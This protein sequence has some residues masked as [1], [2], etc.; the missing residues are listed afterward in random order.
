MSFSLS[1]IGIIH[2]P[3]KQKFAIPRQPRLV[4]SAIGKVEL[5][6][7]YNDLDIVNGL[8]EFTHLWLIFLFHENIESGWSAK[9]RPPRLGGNKKLGVFATRSSFR[10]NPIG[11]SAVKI[12]DIEKLGDSIFIN[13]SGLDLLDGTPIIDLKP[14]IPYADSISEATAGFAQSKPEHSMQVRFEN[15]AK[16]QCLQAE[17]K[18]PGIKKFIEA[19]LQQDPRPAYKKLN[20]DKQEYAVFLYD[21]NVKWQ[22]ENNCCIVT[23]IDLASP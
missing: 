9:V 12:I 1:P 2:S 10:P 7:P 16:Q 18:H 13:I 11:M 20:K 3:Y 23:A 21:Y 17:V 8:E 22:V 19:V 15:Q 4:E 5:F 6:S 14:Y